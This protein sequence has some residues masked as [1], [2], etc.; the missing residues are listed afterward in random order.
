MGTGTQSDLRESEAQTEP[1][2][3]DYVV[4]EGETPE[5]LTLTAFKHGNGLPMGLREVELVER[6]RLKRS[7]E[8]SF[9]PVTDDRS[10][11]LRAKM[12]EA[13]EQKQWVDREQDLKRDQDARLEKLVEQLNDRSAALE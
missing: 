10:F 13:L 7:V 4:K 12:M 2:T 5:V 8:A 6:A 11:G 3:P 1:F 9:P